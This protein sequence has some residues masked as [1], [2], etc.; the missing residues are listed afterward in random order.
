VR[1]QRE[2]FALLTSPKF[3]LHPHE[4]MNGSIGHRSDFRD[5]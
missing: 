1:N 4:E 5:A 2:I 3:A